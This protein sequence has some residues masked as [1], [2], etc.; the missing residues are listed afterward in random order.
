VRNRSN[1]TGDISKNR[2][3]K[4]VVEWDRYQK[5]RFLGKWIL[6]SRVK[7]GNIF[8]LDDKTQIP[9]SERFYLGGASSVRGYPEQ[10][11]GPVLFETDGTA[12]AVGGKLMV[13]ANIEF[14]IPL[15]WLLWGEIFTDAGNVWSNTSN[16]NAG[17]I[18]PTTGL[19]LAFLTPLG[20]IRFDYGI[21]LRP[22]DFE[23]AG[24]FHISIAFA[25]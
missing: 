9:V 12:R 24:E 11:L 5:T 16:F 7:I 3:I 14:R 21:K 10:L 15:I 6:A 20:P 25:F 17:D 22:E 4:L 19:G 8:A 23:S 13:L 1:Q 18:K 2:F